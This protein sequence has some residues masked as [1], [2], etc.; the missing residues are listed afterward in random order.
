MKLEE[1]VEE[2][3][4]KDDGLYIPY[5]VKNKQN[6]FTS[7]VSKVKVI[8]FINESKWIKAEKIKA[9]IQ[10]IMLAMDNPMGVSYR[11]QELEEQLNELEDDGH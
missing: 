8:Q 11:L 5:S 7:V 10:G 9:K 3:F 2:Y 1:E 4:D 6:E